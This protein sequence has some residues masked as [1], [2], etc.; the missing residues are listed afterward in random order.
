M[1]FSC[2][3]YF[4]ASRNSHAFSRSRALIQK[5]GCQ[6]RACHSQGRFAGECRSSGAARATRDDA[7]DRPISSSDRANVRRIDLLS[8]TRTRERIAPAIAFGGRP[9][10][11]ERRV[12]GDQ[13]REHDEVP[14]ACSGCKGLGGS[15][16]ECEDGE[17]TLLQGIR[18]TEGDG[19]C[20]LARCGLPGRAELA[21]E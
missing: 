13:H 11:R 16:R 3:I 17:F 9:D 2:V 1:R 14:R 18:A 5:A 4:S 7:N 19:G 21:A 6:A 10:P 8:H 15:Q 12:G 20:T